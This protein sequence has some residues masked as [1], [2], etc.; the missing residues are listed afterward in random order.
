MYQAAERNDLEL[1]VAEHAALV[2]RIAYH[3]L[4]RLASN[5]Q[6]D[7]LIQAG[8]VGLIEA[9]KRF[10]P[11]QG[12]SFETYAGIRIRGAMLDEVRQ[13]SW[14]PRSAHRKAR[15]LNEAIRKVEANLGRAARDAEVAAEL[16]LSLEEYYQWVQASASFQVFGFEDVDEEPRGDSVQ[17]ES[18][19]MAGPLSRLMDGDFKDS[20][21][22][23]IAGLPEREAL[24]LS[25]YYGDE[26]NLRE[27][28]EVLGVTESRVSQI[29]SQALVRLRARMSNWRE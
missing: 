12:A 3:L 25:L 1:L 20:L 11:D 28:G 26:L 10:R 17:S 13:H 16:G 22:E 29:H 23:A 14:G 9:A 15:A 19:E 21:A 27:I 8:I 7:D 24:V 4:P 18:A 5:V 6:V 2:K